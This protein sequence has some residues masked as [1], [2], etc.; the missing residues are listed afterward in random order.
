MKVI[1][2]DIDGVMNSEL[3]ARKRHAQRWLRLETYKWWFKVKVR[4]V[5]NGLEHKAISLKDLKET[6]KEKTFEYKF[7]RLKSQTDPQAWKYLANLINETGAKIC[8][9][10]VWKHHF[11]D[12]Y[13]WDRAFVLMGLPY[14]TGIGITGDRR[15]L[16]G[17]EIKEWLDSTES[18]EKYAIIDD[19]RDMLPEQM[20]SFFLT[21]S[22]CGLSPNIC[23]RT[24]LHLNKP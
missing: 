8:V 12:S 2:L 24:K 4:F 6:S 17:T 3:Y 5:L 18:V 16:R 13:D 22:Y 11:K 23:Y 1:F 15:T 19:D 14:G 9:S 21:D 7:A 20:S 10:S